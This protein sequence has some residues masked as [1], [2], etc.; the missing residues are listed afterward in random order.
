MYVYV[1]VYMC[2]YVFGYMLVLINSNTVIPMIYV[3]WFFVYVYGT[4]L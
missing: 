2:M 3:S 1:G 4:E